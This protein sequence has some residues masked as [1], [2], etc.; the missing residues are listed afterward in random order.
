[1]KAKVSFV[2][3]G[4]TLLNACSEQSSQFD[5]NW[6]TQTNGCKENTELVVKAGIA[7]LMV[8]PKGVPFL[9][10]G[11]L[12]NNN[13]LLVELIDRNITIRYNIEGNKLTTSEII[14]P[15]GTRNKNLDTKTK[16]GLDLVRCRS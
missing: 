10:F 8:T 2:L 14:S 7:Y 9:K 16:A 12:E 13:S 4:V 11:K 15:D 1:M 6:S 3:C 5:G